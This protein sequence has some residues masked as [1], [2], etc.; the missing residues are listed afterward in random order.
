MF[1]VSATLNTAEHPEAP[2]NS[3]TSTSNSEHAGSE[4]I[5]DLAETR[6]YKQ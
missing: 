6:Y 1:G 4:N 2:A 3:A 5:A